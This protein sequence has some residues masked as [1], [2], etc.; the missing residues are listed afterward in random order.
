MTIAK[1]TKTLL[2]EFGGTII[3]GSIPRPDSRLSYSGN[4]ANNNWGVLKDSIYLEMNSRTITIVN[5]VYKIL[6]ATT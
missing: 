2:H 3:V 6:L 1:R 5:E 4:R